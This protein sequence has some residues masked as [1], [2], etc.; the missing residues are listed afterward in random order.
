MEA[1]AYLSESTGMPFPT[2]A[3][4]LAYSMR[5]A[6]HLPRSRKISPMRAKPRARS[7]GISAHSEC[8][9]PC[10]GSPLKRSFS[11]TCAPPSGS[12]RAAM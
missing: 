10:F 5:A 11:A 1:S 7:S 3:T 9:P 12:G 6:P 8:A 2:R 4:A